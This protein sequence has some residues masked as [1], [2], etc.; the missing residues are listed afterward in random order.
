M[1]TPEEHVQDAL[2]KFWEVEEPTKQAALLTPEETKV[3]DQYDS[4]H[5]F[6]PSIGKYQVVLPRNDKDLTLGESRSQ[7]LLI[8]LK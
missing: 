7:T 5:V 1:P 4:T 2:V 8:S 3:Q 6:L